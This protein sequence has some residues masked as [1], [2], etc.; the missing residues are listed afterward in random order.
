MLRV[1]LLLAL[2]AAL[3]AP[4]TASLAHHHPGYRACDFHWWK[5]RWHTKQLIRCQSERSEVGT[6]VALRVARCES[7]LRPKAY[8]PASGASGIFQQLSR[9]WP[10][11][12]K[13]YGFEDWDVFNG[14]ANIIVSLR[15]AAHDG[16]GHWACY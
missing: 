13:R 5:G 14:R 16:W 8:N 9:Y 10:R 11:R 4:A 3:L 12:A 15:M 1:S 7:G 6:D 2:V